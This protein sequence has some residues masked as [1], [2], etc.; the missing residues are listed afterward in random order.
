MGLKK[1]TLI[2]YFLFFLHLQTH[3]LHA[4][5]R[6]TTQLPSVDPNHDNLQV[7]AVESKPPNGDAF[8][9]KSM[10][11]AVVV[12]KGSFGGG[13][14]GRGVGGGRSGGGGGGRGVG[15]G[16]SGGGGRTYGGG[17]I[18]PIPIYGGGSHHGGHRSSG[19][20][21]SASCWL[22]LSTLVGLVLVF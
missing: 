11:L 6:S 21:E 8:A 7:Q 18:R 22:G 17:G 10:E 15:G 13:G 4:I 2:L 14:G 3:F 9:E 5:S 16:R 20:R 12:K 19:G 1:A